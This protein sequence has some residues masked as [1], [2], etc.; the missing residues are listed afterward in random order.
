MRT[1]I[2]FFFIIFLFSCH[3]DRPKNLLSPA[4]MQSVYYDLIQADHMS[5]EMVRIDSSKKILLENQKYIGQV[6]AIHKITKDQLN[7]NL[8]Y[9][10][11]HPD[12]L[13][14]IFDSIQI[15]DSRKLTPKF[16]NK[17]EKP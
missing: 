12:L 8:K 16:G 1:G 15:Q 6:L 7:I 5:Q 11:K 2:C 9:Y 17:Y 13:A 14:N 10:Q 4:D 3:T